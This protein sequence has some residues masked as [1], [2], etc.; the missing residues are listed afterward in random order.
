MIVN[1]TRNIIVRVGSGLSGYIYPFG[2]INDIN[3]YI[4][5]EIQCGININTL[6]ILE[7]T[8]IENVI[9]VGSSIAQIDR[10]FFNEIQNMIGSDANITDT[11]ST[12]M[13]SVDGEVG[14]GVHVYAP[15]ITNTEISNTIYVGS[16]CAVF[17][18]RLRKLSNID[19]NTMTS[20]DA[21][22]LCDID[23]EIIE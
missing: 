20:I 4:S 1:N 8:S 7:E 23:R 2:T 10:Y 5:P 6:P 16:D 18:A 17:Y 15:N 13:I 19:P 21:Q 3:V 11:Y 14:V 22:N 9:Y 12:K